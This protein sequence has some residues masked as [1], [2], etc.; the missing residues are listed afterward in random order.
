MISLCKF[1]TFSVLGLGLS[2]AQ[3]N[4]AVCMFPKYTPSNF[5]TYIDSAGLSEC[6]TPFQESYLQ[7]PIAEDH[8]ITIF[9]NMIKE[10]R[11][12]AERKLLFNKSLHAILIHYMNG[13]QMIEQ[14][15]NN[16]Q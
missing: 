15:H 2:L 4:V 12:C 8:V 3:N 10:K 11:E 1:I 6:F 16:I 5:I 9:S 7:N 14:I 13:R